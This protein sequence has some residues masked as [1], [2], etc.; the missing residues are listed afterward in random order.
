LVFQPKPWDEYQVGDFSLA[1][2][3]PEASIAAPIAI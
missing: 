1:G 3:N 2:Y